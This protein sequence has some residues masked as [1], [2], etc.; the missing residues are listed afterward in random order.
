MTGQESVREGM[1]V[2]GPGDEPLGTVTHMHGDAFDLSDGGRRIPLTAVARVAR[3]RVY[4]RGPLDQYQTDTVLD[5]GTRAAGT[6]TDRDE[7]VVPV[8]EERLDV[9]KRPTELGEVTIEKDVVTEQREV[10]VDL[11]R[12]EV[13]VER[14]DVEDRPLRAGEQ[15]FEDQ[16]IRVPIRGEEAVVDK[17]QVVT[18]EVVVDKEQ[19]TERQTVADTVRRQDVEVDQSRVRG[20]REGIVTDTD[21][22]ARTP[23]AGAATPTPDTTATPLTGAAAGAPAGVRGQVQEGLDVIG[24]DN[25]IVGRV[26]EVRTSDFLV[27]RSMQRDVYVP[28]DAVQGINQ[29]GVVLTVAS[30]E[31]DDQGWQKPPLL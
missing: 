18:G 27:D 26:K 4:V 16:T 11:R 28:F 23:V 21:T 2:Y 29:Y 6:L 14:R 3:G 19:T 13:H 25:T 22:A 9:E 17:E 15:A 10:P 12:E 24:A 8:V 1:P 7:I 31:V 5:Q 30:N 20:A